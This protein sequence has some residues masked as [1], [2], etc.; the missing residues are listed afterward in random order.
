M[1]QI[2]IILLSLISLLMTSCA[3]E[4]DFTDEQTNESVPLIPRS[5]LFDNPEQ[6]VIGLSPD[7]SKI[8]YCAPVNGVLNIWV[9]PADNPKAAKPVTNDTRRGIEIY[10]WAYTNDHILYLQDKNGDMNWQIYCL[11]LSSRKIKN[12]TPFEG[13]Q[14]WIKTLSP[15]FPDEVIIELNKR[16]P[17]FADIYKLDIITG[18]LTLIQKNDEGF[19]RFY[20][21]DDYRVRFGIKINSDGEKEIFEKTEKGDWKLFSKIE[22]EDDLTTD[23]IGFDKTGEIMY[24]WDSRGRNTA[25]LYAVNTI[26]GEKT[27]IADDPKADLVDFTGENILIH[28]KEKTI[29]AVATNYE[30]KHWRIIDP[31]IEGDIKYL[32]TVAKDDFSVTSQTLDGD[33][34]IVTYTMDDGPSIIYYYDRNKKEARLLSSGSKELEG[35]PFAKMHPAII[36]SR[37][38]LNLVSYYT[39]PMN[40]DSNGDRIPDKPLP[41]ILLVHGGPE[42]R[43]IW[44]F[45][46]KHQWL[47]NRGY[48]VLSTNF[49]G[50]TGFGKNFTN[51]GNLE[52]GRKMQDDL[53]DALNW[54]IQEG[55]ADPQ[56]VAIMGGSY[57]G[58]AT[59]AGLTF[60]PETFACG[61]DMYGPSNL[62]TLLENFPAWM[63]P[64][65]GRLATTI[66]GN[67]STEKGRI[68]LAERSPLNYVDCIQRPLLVEQG[69]NDPIVKR[70]E[71]DQIVQAMQEKNL[72]VIYVLFSDE[73]HYIARPENNI[74][75]YAVA[76]AFL[77]Q[78]LGGRLEPID[79]DLQGSSITIPVGAKEIHGLEEALSKNSVNS[80][81]REAK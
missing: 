65:M 14:A 48:A 15:K 38:G 58:Y 8:S 31:S 17:R 30:R 43:D 11:N 47:A 73:G 69:S 23:I 41:M 62:I 28:P 59:L 22:K 9:G 42:E 64:S 46:P 5:I 63:E 60:T 77:S 40:S 74:A 80:T 25:A 70:N 29:Q 16:D 56:K 32:S 19:V 67:L 7:G 27:L 49:R 2:F 12:L 71:S 10:N 66:G 44:G 24:M 3:V 54:S 39:L 53:I 72:S 68:L 51:A 36:K 37:D 61:V 1:K 21:D 4:S 78:H 33:A 20:I 81:G 55:I 45:N 75:F 79:D 26:T 57:G 13:T 34:W 35:R 6:A 52:W 76:E 18:N 50:S